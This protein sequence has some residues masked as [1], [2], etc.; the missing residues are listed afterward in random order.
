[1]P[2]GG[3]LLH[4]RL[5]DMQAP[6]RVDDDD[7]AVVRSGPLQSLAHGHY[8]ILRLLTVD[9][10][11][12]LPAE[13]LELVDR[14]GPLEVGGDEARLLAVLAEQERELRGRGR[15]ARPLK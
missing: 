9:G 2:H 7:V 1:L 3:E 4:Q 11:L 6:G 8:G 13:L 15:L 10:D 12:D 14:G 5:V